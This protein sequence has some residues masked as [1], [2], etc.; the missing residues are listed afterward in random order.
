MMDCLSFFTSSTFSARCEQRREGS[1]GK[2][3]GGS[4][5]VGVKPLQ[6]GG[7]VYSLSCMAVA[8]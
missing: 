8:V 4:E 5:Q 3:G 7:G 2:I 6:W 1:E